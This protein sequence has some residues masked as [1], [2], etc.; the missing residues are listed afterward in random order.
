MSTKP[1]TLL[2]KYD[3]PISHLDFDYVEKCSNAREMEKIVNILRSGEEGYYPDLTKRAEEKLEKLKPDSKLFRT[4]ENLLTKHS[5]SAKEWNSETAPIINWYTEAKQVDTV[6]QQMK[7]ESNN[8]IQNVVARKT[9]KLVLED[10]KPNEQ[11]QKSSVSKSRNTFTDYSA[12][13]KFDAES[14]ILKMELDEEKLN[15]EVERKNK[16][17]L[18][19]SLNSHDNFDV[20]SLTM[21]EREKL[22]IR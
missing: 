1:K 14:E 7:S 4:E 11:L 15:E 3:I 18:K 10:T 8:G 16:N 17:I 6:L 12:W 9:E 5:L 21:I 22:S 19:T 20:D 13:D 2:Q